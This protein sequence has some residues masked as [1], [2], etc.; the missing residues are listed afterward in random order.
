MAALMTNAERATSVEIE[1][2]PAMIAA[3]RV[4]FNGFDSRF[5]DTED[6]VRDIYVAMVL[7]KEERQVSTLSGSCP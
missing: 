4:A 6:A 5:E 1:I 7:A 2:T 3:G